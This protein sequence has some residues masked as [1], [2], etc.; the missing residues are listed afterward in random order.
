MNLEKKI[1]GIETLTIQE[2]ID[3]IKPT[4]LSES[5]ISEKEADN[6]L[7]SRRPIELICW[8]NNIL[9]VDT[10]ELPTT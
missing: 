8:A 4:I 3:I 9:F 7:L 1:F 5:N 10:S 2:L 6:I